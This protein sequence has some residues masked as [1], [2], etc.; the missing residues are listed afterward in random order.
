MIKQ[1]HSTFSIKTNDNRDRESLYDREI[2]FINFI[3]LLEA[4]YIIYKISQKW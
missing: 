1:V 3:F 2:S 4:N